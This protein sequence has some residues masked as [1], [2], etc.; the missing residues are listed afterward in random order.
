M[1]RCFQDMWQILMKDFLNGAKMILSRSCR[2]F[3]KS[4]KTLND[5]LFGLDEHQLMRTARHPAYGKWNINGWTQFFLL[6]EA[7]HFFTIL[8]LTSQIIA[9]E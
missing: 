7:H 3:I 5:F 9:P 8:K 2:N 1:T 4:R 6:H